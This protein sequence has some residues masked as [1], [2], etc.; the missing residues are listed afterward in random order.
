MNDV[1]AID[2]AD[3]LIQGITQK[4]TADLKERRELE[5]LNSER[6]RLEECG[7]ICAIVKTEKDKYVLMRVPA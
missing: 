2:M 1:I 7:I 4:V 6:L 3:A 5:W